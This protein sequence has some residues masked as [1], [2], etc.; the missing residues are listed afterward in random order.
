MSGK[1]KKPIVVAGLAALAVA[2]VGSAM[3]RIGPWYEALAK[4]DWNPPNWV[5]GPVWTL[6]YALAVFAA[7]RGWRACD[8]N[9]E[10]S[11]LISLFFINGVL[12]V[13]WSALFFTF[14]RPD[15]ALAEVVTLWLSVLVLIVFL[16]RKDKPASLVLIPYL[17]WVAFAG[18][19]NARIVALNGPFG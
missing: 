16:Y 14:K 2:V 10:R 19:L 15:L 7:V 12:N 1:S 4:P 17:V 13:L 3:T 18:F 11:W 9:R 8:T 6:I 5:F